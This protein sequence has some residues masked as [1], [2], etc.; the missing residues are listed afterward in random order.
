MT[1]DTQGW[2]PESTLDAGDADEA[3]ASALWYSEERWYTCDRCGQMF[4]KSR[5]IIEDETGLRV[6]T[7]GP[8]DHDKPSP[9][10]FR[11]RSMSRLFLPED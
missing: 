7:V 8:H 5:T 2:P 11:R 9:D 10:D 4:P 3:D 1:R 6:C